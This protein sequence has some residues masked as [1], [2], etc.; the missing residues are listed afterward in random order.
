[1][2]P[3]PARRFAP[4]ELRNGTSNRVPSARTGNGLIIGLLEAVNPEMEFVPQQNVRPL[5]LVSVVP[6]A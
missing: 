4:S 6:V 1:M 2:K 3:E 5:S